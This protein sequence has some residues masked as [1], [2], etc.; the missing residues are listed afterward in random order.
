MSFD[1]E[2]DLWQNKWTGNELAQELN[3]PANVLKH[4]DYDYFPDF[5]SHE[6]RVRTIH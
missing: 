4:T 2:L 1:S 3:S 5:A 6:L